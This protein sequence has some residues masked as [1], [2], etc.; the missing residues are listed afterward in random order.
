M[1]TSIE[2]GLALATS[3]TM[4]VC[5]VGVAR[6]QSPEAGLRAG[7][8]NPFGEATPTGSMSDMVGGQWLKPPGSSE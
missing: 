6:G 8:A 2:G 5:W 3:L 4:S 1:P 7:Y